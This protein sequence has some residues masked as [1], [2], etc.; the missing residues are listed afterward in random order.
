TVKAYM[1]YAGNIY[2]SGNLSAGTI[3]SN[4]TIESTG[5]IKA[6]EYLHL[7]GQATL[8]ANCTANGLVGRDST[9]RVLSC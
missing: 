6:G 1:N 7:N 9:V 4:G 8:I 2:A 3:K 5:R